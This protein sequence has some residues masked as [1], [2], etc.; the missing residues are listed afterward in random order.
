MYLRVCAVGLICLYLVTGG[1]ASTKHRQFKET[2]Y[3]SGIKTGSS[4]IKYHETCVWVQVFFISGDFFK[5]LKEQDTPAGGVQFF[6]G[7][8]TV[9][10]FPEYITVDVEATVYKCS[11]KTNEIL[12]P[13]YA[14]GLMS[15]A[16]FEL[17]WGT[18]AATL[19]AHLLSKT[20]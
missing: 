18:G 12:P 15:G 7:G 1:S 19:P 14:S 20:E 9:E 13:D 5:E 11:A 8:A 2:D 16:S 4:I 10:N 17:N 3:G 6:R